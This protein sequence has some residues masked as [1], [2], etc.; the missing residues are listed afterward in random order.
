[1]TFKDSGFSTI[2]GTDIPFN[3]PNEIYEYFVEDGDDLSEYGV[4]DNIIKDFYEN[5]NGKK[6]Y[7]WIVENAKPLYLKTEDL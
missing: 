5:G 2:I 1:M 6:L 4:P 7:K 3:D